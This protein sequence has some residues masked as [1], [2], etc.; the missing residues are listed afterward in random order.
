M[1]A[2]KMSSRK[3]VEG[4][5]RE[6]SREFYRYAFLRLSSHEEAEDVV[7]LT[8]IKAFRSFHTF[9]KGSNEKAWLYTIMTNTLRDHLRKNTQRPPE[10]SLSDE[11][12]LE[13]MLVDSKDTPDMVLARKM[14]HERLAGGIANLPELFAAPLLMRDVS[15]MSYKQIADLLKVPIGTVMSRLSRA[16]KALFELMSEGD[17]GA[18]NST[19][20]SEN[21]KKSKKTL[22]PGDEQK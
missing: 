22:K 17:E 21:S 7:Q 19:E 18:S 8:F 14:D 5:V 2:D 15:D 16:R 10:T 1:F 11:D 6:Y 4:W 3:V 9:R 12:E 13:N 20:L